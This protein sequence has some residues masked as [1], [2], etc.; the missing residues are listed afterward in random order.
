MLKQT[1]TG[2]KID[3]LRLRL[4]KRFY[5]VDLRYLIKIRVLFHFWCVFTLVSEH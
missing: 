2:M 3:L 1:T 5:C 4:A